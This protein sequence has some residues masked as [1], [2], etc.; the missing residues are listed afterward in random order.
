VKDG[1]LISIDIPRR[2]LDLKVPEEEVKRRLALWKPPKK[3]LKGCLAHYVS[4]LES[5][6]QK[7]MRGS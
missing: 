5:E 3:T 7:R 4:L 2:L 6:D 1:D